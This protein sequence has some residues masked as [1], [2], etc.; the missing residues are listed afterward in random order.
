MS[1]IDRSELRQE[2]FENARK[3]AKNN[4]LSR[5]LSTPSQLT[6]YQQN[7]IAPDSGLLPVSLPD[8]AL[9]LSGIKAAILANIGTHHSKAVNEAALVYLASLYRDKPEELDIR[10]VQN[11]AFISITTPF[12]E[13]QVQ[14]P[15]PALDAMKIIEESNRNKKQ[16]SNKNPDPEKLHS[17]IIAIEQRAFRNVALKNGIGYAILTMIYANRDTYEILEV[18]QDKYF[19]KIMRTSYP[20]YLTTNFRDFETITKT[21]EQES[22]RIINEAMSALFWGSASQRQVRYDDLLSFNHA[23]DVLLAGGFFDESKAMELKN[24]WIFQQLETRACAQF[25]PATDENELIEE[26]NL[27]SE[28]IGHPF[29]STHMT[30]AFYEFKLGDT[31]FRVLQD[32][33]KRS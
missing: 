6:N 11:R 28:I 14:L 21:P 33:T 8:Q 27:Q 3:E 1:N 17:E 13:Q 20:P 12:Q 16:L 25:G 31:V 7:S 24:T 30:D 29:A 2:E 23:V 5:L 26:Y 10:V 18:F 4:I 32:T 9:L 15:E 19:Q 22:R